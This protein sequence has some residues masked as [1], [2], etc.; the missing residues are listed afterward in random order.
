MGGRGSGYPGRPS[1]PS[2]FENAKAA[3]AAW[4]QVVAA[5]E[6]HVFLDLV[7]LVESGE[8]NR[9]VLAKRMGWKSWSSME[10]YLYRHKLIEV[11]RGRLT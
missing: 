11:V 3:Q 7:N 2:D 9:E 8:R 1:R 10:R 6:A 4:L 5:R